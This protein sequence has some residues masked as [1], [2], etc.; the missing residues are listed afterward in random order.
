MAFD[1]YTHIAA[2]LKVFCFKGGAAGD[3]TVTGITTS[4]K[5]VG[6]CGTKLTADALSTC[7]PA[8][9]GQLNLTSE[10]SIASSNTINNTGGTGSTNAL[11]FAFYM[12]WDA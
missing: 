9:G 11:M 7:L 5:L 4:D 6:V 1:K 3:H 2:P 12:D 10:F 8:S